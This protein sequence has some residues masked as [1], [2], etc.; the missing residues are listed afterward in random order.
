MDKWFSMENI[1]QTYS[2]IWLIKYKKERKEKGRNWSFFLREKGSAPRTCCWRRRWAPRTCTCDDRSMTT[3][4][5]RGLELDRQ[6]TSATEV[7][8]SSF[9]FFLQEK[10][11]RERWAGKISNR[12]GVS[13]RPTWTPTVSTGLIQGSNKRYCC[14][15]VLG[16]LQE[17]WEGK[18]WAGKTQVG[19][20]VSL[21]ATWTPTASGSDPRIKQALLL[22]TCPRL[23]AGKWIGKRWAGKTQV[24]WGVSFSF[25]KLVQVWLF[26]HPF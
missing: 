8:E 3:H 15:C 19:C 21:R 22:C 24:G 9:S 14:A 12:R 16:F 10:V 26:L 20:G 2:K 25:C 1:T 13:F 18:R 17:R 23:F 4:P 5:L 11:G 6:E 7:C